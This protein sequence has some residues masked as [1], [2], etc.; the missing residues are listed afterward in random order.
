L[1]LPTITTKHT[2]NAPVGY[3]GRVHELERGVC[4]EWVNV[5]G[6]SDENVKLN[7]KCGFLQEGNCILT[8]TKNF[9]F[10]RS[11]LR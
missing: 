4:L 2:I 11:K 10:A 3:G 5:G 7:F 6:L 9:I 1:T 8:D